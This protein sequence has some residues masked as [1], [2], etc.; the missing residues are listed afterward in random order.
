MLINIYYQFTYQ[1]FDRPKVVLFE[2]IV[3][4]CKLCC[5]L[6]GIFTISALFFIR[7]A[8]FHVL[9]RLGNSKE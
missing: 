8:V 5:V 6:I 9:V 4:T 1:H 7:G 3:L 2:N